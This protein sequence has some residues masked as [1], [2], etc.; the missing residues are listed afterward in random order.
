VRGIV[1]RS[2]GASGNTNPRNSRSAN[3]D[4]S[5]GNVSYESRTG[6][7]LF[8]RGLD[9]VAAFYSKVLGLSEAHRDDDHILLES[10]GFQLVVHRIPG[11]SATTTENAEPLARRA[12]AAYKPVFFVQSLASV[13]T[14]ASAHGGVREPREKEWS[15]NGVVVCDAV[16][17]EGNVIQFREM[18]RLTQ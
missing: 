2:G 9:Q 18:G 12:R 13:R 3:E 17:L 16:D 7:V 14:T 10:P 8:A 4:S 1:E 6:A 11:H 5:E 15:F